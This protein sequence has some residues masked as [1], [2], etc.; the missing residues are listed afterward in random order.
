VRIISKRR[1]AALRGHRRERVSEK[2]AAAVDPWRT[3]R[4]LQKPAHCMGRIA[5]PR[6]HSQRARAGADKAALKPQRFAVLISSPRPSRVLA[7]PRWSSR[8]KPINS[9]RGDYSVQPLRES[10]RVASGAW[11]AKLKLA[12]PGTIL[13][14]VRSNREVR[15][16]FD[17]DRGRHD[18][19]AGLLCAVVASGGAGK[20]EMSWTSSRR[21]TSAAC[22]ESRRSCTTTSSRGQLRNNHRPSLLVG[23]RP[24]DGILKDALA[25]AGKVHTPARD[26][27]LHDIRTCRSWRS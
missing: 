16:G 9:P 18:C 8:S 17:L 11:R 19:D 2:P 13:V 15:H 21:P 7:R 25:A 24:L 14:T 6:R 26:A 1:R 22:P 12:V 4:R 27:A 10:E 3:A 23:S 20:K 5:Q